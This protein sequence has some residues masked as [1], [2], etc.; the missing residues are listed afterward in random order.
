VERHLEVAAA[1][2]IVVGRMIG[3]SARMA[4]TDIA[5]DLQRRSAEDGAGLHHGPMS[6]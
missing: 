5:G 1:S 6:M 2:A 4:W 3:R